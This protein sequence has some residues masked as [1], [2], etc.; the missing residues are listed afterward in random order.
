MDT[1]L[2]RVFEYMCLFFPATM[3]G[4]RAWLRLCVCY[5]ADQICLKRMKGPEVQFLCK[6]RVPISGRLTLGEKTAQGL[7][8]SR[9][10]AAWAWSRPRM[11][12]YVGCVRPD[13][14]SVRP[15]SG[16]EMP[17][18]T[19]V[20]RLT[21]RHALLQRLRMSV[22]WATRKRTRGRKPMY[23]ACFADAN[24]SP[25]FDTAAV[26]LITTHVGSTEQTHPML[27]ASST[28]VRG[29]FI[30]S[31]DRCSGCLESLQPRFHW[32]R[33]MGALSTRFGPLRSK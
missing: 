2:G 20:L 9:C 15:D 18:R 1:L 21:E 12:R 4:P 8:L 32:F 10:V 33:Q 13:L 25:Y 28:H 6:V 22:A 26:P 24:R 7:T 19:R 5:L 11:R 14:A 16:R 29:A 27:P 23:T 30:M 31:A 17:R 3:R